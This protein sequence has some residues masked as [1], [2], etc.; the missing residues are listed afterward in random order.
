MSDITP[1]EL[2]VDEI[3]TRDEVNFSFDLEGLD[4]T[5]KTLFSQWR[6][7]FDTAVVAEFKESDNTLVKS[8]T[9][10]QTLI[11]TITFHLAASKNLIE[12]DTYKMTLI[13]YSTVDNTQTIMKGTATIVPQITIR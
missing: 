3:Y 2:E 10:L 4:L 5:G 13:S 1:G 6:K 12:P 9:N 11:T 7:A 8:D